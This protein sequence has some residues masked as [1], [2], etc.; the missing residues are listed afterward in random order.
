[1]NIG[2]TKITV[3]QLLLGCLV[4][5]IVIIES[6]KSG[7]FKVF[8]EAAKLL[9][10]HQNI[11]DQW[12]NNRSCKYYYSPLFALLLIPLVTFPD[13][14]VN[15]L[16]LSANVFF[17]ARIWKLT[18]SYFDFSVFN[19]KETRFYVVITMVLTARFLLHNFE[20]MQMTVFILWSVLE[21]FNLFSNK[22]YI[23][24]ALLFAL[25]MNI[26]ILPIVFLPYLLFR[27]KTAAFL[28]VI[29]F[30]GIFLYLP[31]LLVGFG[32]NNFLL[33]EWFKALNPS[34][35]EHSFIDD[36]GGQSLTTLLPTLLMQTVGEV[37]FKRNIA[38]LDVNTV[39]YL[40]TA[41]RAFF[42][43]FTLYFTGFTFFKNPKF[44][45]REFWEISYITL[46]IPI[47]FS[48][49]EKYAFFLIFPATAYIVYYLILARQNNW[50]N[51]SKTKWIVLVSLLCLSFI[52]NTLTSDLFGGRYYETVC[53]HF[54]TIAY[55]SFLLVIALAF[56]KPSMLQDTTKP[57]I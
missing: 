7:D 15:F 12:L 57:L 6:R 34:N 38:N 36:I 24:G 41:A 31:G 3:P 40:I 46:I 52:L 53:D 48:H 22:K 33:A 13:F 28:W 49:Q 14:I 21:S 20:N 47:I 45:L 23:P 50:A 55:G 4:V 32:F 26:K 9:K 2:K 16:W 54:K 27:K 39:N 17:F 42:I 35:I 43:G 29:L 44:K 37:P 19:K 18:A 30:A 10:D 56:C 25:A 8:T 1:M 51:I 5:F 11:Y